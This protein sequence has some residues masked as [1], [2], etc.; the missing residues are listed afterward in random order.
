MYSLPT[1]LSFPEDPPAFFSMVL[2]LSGACLPMFAVSQEW[3]AG[4]K[5]CKA[6]AQ[7]LLLFSYLGNRGRT[8]HFSWVQDPFGAR[9]FFG[10][11][12]DPDHVSR[13]PLLLLVS[14]SGSRQDRW[15]SMLLDMEIS[16]S[17]PLPL[18][19]HTLPRNA[20]ISLD[21][22]FQQSD[23]H[24]PLPPELSLKKHCSYLY[25]SNQFW[26]RNGWAECAIKWIIQWH[27]V[28]LN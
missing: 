13:S 24:R 1:E 25:S 22:L 23:V 26:T 19:G 15:V 10:A 11:L 16:G 12:H 4:K 27:G 7:G 5:D 28:F 8:P 3:D 17:I 14:C 9:S 6:P 21:S 2:F 18:P 20:S